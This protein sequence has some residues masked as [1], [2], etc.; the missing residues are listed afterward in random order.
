LKRPYLSTHPLAFCFAI[1]MALTGL[2]TVAVPSM[3]AQSITLHILPSWVAILSGALGLT[4]GTFCAYG[5]LSIKPQY[6]A[7][8]FAALA[9]VQLV[10]IVNSVAALGFVPSILGIL[11]RLGLGAGCALRTYT[12]V[13]RS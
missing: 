1:S 12:L 6:E 13:V 8:G 3:R 11:L 10:S 2:L 9:A 7:A 4:G 5:I